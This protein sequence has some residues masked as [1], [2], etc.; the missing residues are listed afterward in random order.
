[1]KVYVTNHERTVERDLED[2]L[3]PSPM[4]YEF[5]GQ[6]EEALGMAQKNSRMLGKLAAVLVEKGLMT[7]EEA[8]NAASN[9]DDVSL[10]P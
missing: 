8:L 9:Y 10:T 6:M 7:L 3:T 5:S 1:M 2:V 4:A